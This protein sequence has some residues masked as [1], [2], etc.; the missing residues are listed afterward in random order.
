MAMKRGNELL[1]KYLPHAYFSNMEASN[2]FMVNSYAEALA[3]AIDQHT[4]EASEE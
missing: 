2:H 4:H 1:L 3:V